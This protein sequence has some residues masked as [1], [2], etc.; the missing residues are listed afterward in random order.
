M[1]PAW[2]DSETGAV[3]TT[4]E[5]WLYIK[6]GSFTKAVPRDGAWTGA[7]KYSRIIARW[8]EAQNG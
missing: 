3:V 4:T 6:V 5:H 8:K 7:P 2:V 1:T